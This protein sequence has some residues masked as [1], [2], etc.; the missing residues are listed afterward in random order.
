MM[1]KTGHAR[2]NLGR[3][4]LWILMGP[5]AISN[6]R[7]RMEPDLRWDDRYRDSPHADGQVKLR[8]LY[9]LFSTWCTYL[10]CS[11]PLSYLTDTCLCEALDSAQLRGFDRC[12]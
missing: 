3:T 10:L 11:F 7:G 8:Y 5:D 1:T 9:I 2:S 12:E 4:E 6:R